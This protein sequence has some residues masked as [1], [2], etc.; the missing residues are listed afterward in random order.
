MESLVVARR[1]LS[2]LAFSAGSALCLT[3]LTGPSVAADVTGQLRVAIT[4]DGEPSDALL[5]LFA[6]DPEATP[7]PEQLW[8]DTDSAGMR[9]ITLEPGRYWLKASAFEQA[10]Q[11]AGQTPDRASSQVLTVTEGG[12]TDVAVDLADGST[13]SGTVADRSAAR[14]FVDVWVPDASYPAGR[15]RVGVGAVVAD[16]GSFEVYDVPT[17]SVLVHTWSADGRESWYGG[18]DAASAEPVDVSAPQPVDGIVL[19]GTGLS[20]AIEG[21]LTTTRGLPV[22]HGYVQVLT[23][24]DRGRWRSTTGYQSATADE[25]GHFRLPLPE[26]TYRLLVQAHDRVAPEWYADADSVLAARDLVVA[27]GHNAAVDAA[28]T[29]RRIQTLRDPV[30]SGFRRTVRVGDRL[31]VG[32]AFLADDTARYTCRW[33]RDD[34]LIRRDTERC[35]YTAQPADR[36]H[37]L[38]AKLRVTHRF[39]RS[40]RAETAPTP[41]VRRRR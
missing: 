29:P 1:L 40:I 39:F 31:N 11:W 23:E 21:T 15:Q 2:L 32:N 25:Q 34:R 24:V 16:D 37:R 14:T 30:V 12:A 13:I 20:G 7:L 9:S 19:D 33:F 35:V 10:S 6:V 8:Y 28:L 41:V 36:G 3:A 38:S 5:E 26:G 4:V 27:P 18:P 17:A 22:G